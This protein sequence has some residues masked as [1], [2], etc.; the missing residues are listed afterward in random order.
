MLK[1]VDRARKKR[2]QIEYGV[3]FTDSN[4][5]KCLASKTTAIYFNQTII[6]LLMVE[7]GRSKRVI[8]TKN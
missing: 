5:V 6:R 7:V 4:R 2:S 8:K 1:N 3:L